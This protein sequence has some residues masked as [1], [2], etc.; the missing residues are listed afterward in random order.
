[1]GSALCVSAIL[2]LPPLMVCVLSQATLL[3]L[4]VA[5]LELSEAGPGLRALPWSKQLRFRFSGTPQRRR[6]RWASILCPSPFRAV[7]VIGAWR[8]QSP[9]V[10]AATYHLPYPCHSVFWVYNRRAFLGVLCV[11]PGELISGCDPHDR[12]RPSGIQRSLGYQR[13][14]L[15][16]WSVMPLWGRDCPLPALAAL[17]YLSLAEDGL[18]CSQLA[19]LS[20]L[21]CEWA[22]RCL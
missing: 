9:P 16:V 13:S 18:V 15:A 19:L 14:L 17:A 5:L 8:V 12:C 6:F 1:M 21:F 22:W 2:G 4:W 11:S 7:Q 10:G 20:P 3:R